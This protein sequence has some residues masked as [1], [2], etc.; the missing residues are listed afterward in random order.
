MKTYKYFILTLFTGVLFYSNG[1][2]AAL[3]G[4]TYN[5]PIS[6]SDGQ[7]YT[8]YYSY[9]RFSNGYQVTSA[10][11]LSKYSLFTGDS[12]LEEKYSTNNWPSYSTW[13]SFSL[14]RANLGSLINEQIISAKIYVNGYYSSN[15]NKLNRWN[16]RGYTYGELPEYKTTQNIYYISNNDWQMSN[17]QSY[18]ER[19]VFYNN[20]TQ[21]I[22]ADGTN[23]NIP[24]IE[25]IQ[26]LANTDVELSSYSSGTVNFNKTAIWDITDNFLDIIDNSEKSDG[27]FTF[28]FANASVPPDFD[29][30]ELSNVGTSWNANL[31][32]SF[33]PNNSMFIEIQTAPVP[34]PSSMIMG[35]M[36]LGS[37]FGLRKNRK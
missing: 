23:F 15:T 36:G 10:K 11:S 30:T 2:N 25:N 21:K 13:N 37:L 9:Y 14:F 33:Q 12:R 4:N 18:Q 35:L 20:G 7:S 1:A 17:S 6:I 24:N 22:Y 8:N 32:I 5:V 29:V 16:G 28:M 3:L 34:E 19:Q 26:Y 31:G 27:I